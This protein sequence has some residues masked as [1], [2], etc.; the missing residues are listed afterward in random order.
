M[1]RDFLGTKSGKKAVWLFA[2]LLV[3]LLSSNGLNVLNSYVSRDFMNAIEQSREADF[4]KLA[5]FFLVVYAA[6]TA[7]AVFSSFSEQRL[8][9]LWRYWLTKRV[10]NGYLEPRVYYLVGESGAVPNPDQRIS[11]DI[12]V[13]TVNSL[14]FALMMT[15]S[16][17]SVLVFSGVMWSISPTLLLVSVGYALVGSLVTFLVG[18]PL[19][20]LNSQQSDKEANFRSDVR[21]IQENA[22]LVALQ[23]R[24][25]RL[26]VRLMS[27]LD[28]LTK[29]MR[30]IIGVNRNVGFF[31]NGYNYLI[32][33]IP[34]LIVAPL[35]IHGKAQFGIIA[36]S[37]V[38][39]AVLVNA[40]SILVSQF[41]SI[42]TLAAA[43]LRVGALLKAIKAAE[44]GPST[45]LQFREEEDMLAYENVTLSSADDGRVLIKD[46]SVRIKRGTNVLIAG[47]AER[48][49]MVLFRATAGIGNHGRG[50]IVRPNLDRILFLPEKAF[51]SPGSLREMILPADKKGIDDARI[52]HV[53]DSLNIGDIV[54]VAGGLDHSHDNW[55]NLLSLSE[56]KLVMFARMLLSEPAFCFLD[57]VQ[58]ALTLEQT[59]HV[60][61]MLCDSKITYINMGEPGDRCECYNALLELAENGAWHWTEPWDGGSGCAYT[62]R[63]AGKK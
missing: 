47:S 36:Q 57:H 1:V 23:H 43:S 46:L 16:T 58:T 29:N 17:F 53:L 10:L 31:T 63:P 45:G 6:S 61:G 28:E 24:E 30:K 62:P 5:G 27:R 13:I 35:F 4:W 60:L 34:A 15:N 50:T 54:E 40:F 19:I 55:D 21:H 14:S 8:G 41:T 51:L 26:K 49:K 22:E 11:E 32:Q 38:A 9:L 39:F 52:H 42:S 44:A 37:A 48:A 12:R 59:N 25:S 7:V 56:Q 3:L 18:R 33:I 20:R 2:T